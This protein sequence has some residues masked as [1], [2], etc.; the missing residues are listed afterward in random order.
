MSY[1]EF[2]H[3]MRWQAT[4][5]PSAQVCHPDSRILIWVERDNQVSVHLLAPSPPI[6]SYSPNWWVDENGRTWMLCDF[7]DPTVLWAWAKSFHQQET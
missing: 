5:I 1:P 4:P 2:Q 3:T 7:N 6:S